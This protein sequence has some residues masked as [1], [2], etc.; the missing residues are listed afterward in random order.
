MAFSIVKRGGAPAGSLTFQIGGTSYTI[1]DASNNVI[2]VATPAEAAELSLHPFLQF[3]GG[4]ATTYVPP[5]TG[6]S[7]ELA[8]AEFTSNI[9]NMVNTT[10]ATSSIP[11]QVAFT[12]AKRP[13]YC[14][15]HCPFL[16]VQTATVADFAFTDAAYSVY[17]SI[18]EYQ[19]VNF[20]EGPFEMWRRFATPGNYSVRVAAKTTNASN[21]FGVNAGGAINP[22]FLHAVEF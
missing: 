17:G 14:H 3:Q 8:Y 12:V 6:D 2:S 16:V 5:S 22:C 7:R 21:S 4:T 18:E 13:V 20:T 11:L 10:Y 19:G 1:D 9:I 15:F